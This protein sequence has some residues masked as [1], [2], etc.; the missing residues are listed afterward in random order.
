VAG[1]KTPA[2]GITLLPP[3]K[4][5]KEF[6]SFDKL[7]G[8]FSGVKN[9][10]SAE[11]VSDFAW[12]LGGQVHLMLDEAKYGEHKI[13]ELSEKLELSESTLYSYKKFYELYDKDDVDNKFIKKA[14]S[15]HSLSYLIG[16]Q[17]PKDRARLETK[18]L[19]GTVKPKDLPELVKQ[20]NDKS[21]DKK[22]AAGDKS[23]ETAAERALASDAPS[24][25][26][27]ASRLIKAKLNRIGPVCDKLQAAGEAA[28]AELDKLDMISHKDTY[29]SVMDV[30]AETI[31]KVK[32]S[33]ELLKDLASN[34]T[35]KK[36]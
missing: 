23:G 1:E 30:L 18:L 10:L 25:D 6:P 5:V 3:R 21:K 22:L 11:T 28:L 24:K 17:D 36:T 14:V 33:Q 12:E 29:A 35:K 32:A 19:E 31:H 7:V 20:A 26:T 2:A 13:E 15:W 4:D 34:L 27:E 9:K 8:Y 16:V